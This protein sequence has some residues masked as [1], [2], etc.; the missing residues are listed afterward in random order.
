[1][2][3]VKIGAGIALMVFGAILVERRISGASAFGGFS[4]ISGIMIVAL[5]IGGAV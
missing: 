3:L 1:M 2:P 5:S 4:L